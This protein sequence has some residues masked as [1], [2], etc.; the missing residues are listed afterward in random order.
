MGMDK[1]RV[2]DLV[3]YKIM[4]R[5]SLFVTSQRGETRTR[6]R[7]SSSHKRRTK[8]HSISRLIPFKDA[9]GNNNLMREKISTNRYHR[10]RGKAMTNTLPSIEGGVSHLRMLKLNRGISQHATGNN[11][12]LVSRTTKEEGRNTRGASGSR[13]KSRI[14]RV[15]R[16]LCTTFRRFATSFISRRDRGSKGKGTRGG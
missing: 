1:S 5:R 16:N 12:R 14:K 3:N 6:S 10:M 7:R 8:R 2:N 13:D 15:R 4:R 11:S 9:I